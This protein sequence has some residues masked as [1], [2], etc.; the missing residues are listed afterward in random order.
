MKQVKFYGF[1]VGGR[2]SGKPSVYLSRS[3]RARRG[4]GFYSIT[5]MDG[6]AVRLG[7]VRRFEDR[8]MCV[9]ADGTSTLVA[10]RWAHRSLPT[11]RWVPR[12]GGFTVFIREIE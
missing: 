2:D 5:L 9:A 10:G 7:K 8:D 3:L 11:G 1:S 12:S 4:P 6:G